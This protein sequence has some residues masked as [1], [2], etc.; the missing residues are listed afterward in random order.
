M[1]LAWILK[2]QRITTVL[3]G[4]SKPEQV[5]NSIACLQNT[6]FSQEELSTIN[7]ILS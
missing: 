1:A 2:D 6:S 4:A 3:I 7:D 5:L